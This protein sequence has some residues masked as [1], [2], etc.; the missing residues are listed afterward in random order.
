M[1][2][3]ITGLVAPKKKGTD[4]GGDAIGRGVGGVGLG[5]QGISWSQSR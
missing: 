3:L 2:A 4:A 1:V 5:C